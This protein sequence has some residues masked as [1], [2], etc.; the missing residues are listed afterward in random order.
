[1]MLI[2]LRVLQYSPP[3]GGAA[4]PGAAGVVSPSAKYVIRELLGMRNRFFTTPAAPNI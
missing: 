4:A 3:E 1:M 2:G